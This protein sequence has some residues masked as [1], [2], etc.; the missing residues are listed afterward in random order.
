M[1]RIY[2]PFHV[3]LSVPKTNFNFQRG[4]EKVKGRVHAKRPKCISIH[5]SKL[6][7]FYNLT[8]LVILVDLQNLVDM[9]NL[10]NLLILMNL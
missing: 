6:Y 7:K 3:D 10:V 1:L 9:A 4:N 2:W 5:P 8:D